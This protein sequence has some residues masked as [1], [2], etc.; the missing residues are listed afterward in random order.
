MA[1]TKIAFFETEKWEEDYLREKLAT[2]K[3]ISLDFSPTILEPNNLAKARNAGILAVFIYSKIQKEILDALP[4]LKSIATMSTGF[5]H[6][7][8]KECQ[9][10]KIKVSNVPTY[11]SNTVAEHTF[12]LILALSRKLVPSIERTRQGDFT[13][14]GL[15]GFDLSGKTIGIIGLGN[16]GKHVARIA[17]G[18]E[19]NILAFD[20]MPD[21]SFG[22]KMK[23]KFMEVDELLA[24]S[25]IITLH[26]PDN[27]KTHH[28]INKNNIEK[29]KKGACLVNTA[30]GGLVETEALLSA[31]KQDILAGAGLDVLEEECVVKEEKELLAAPFQ[32]KCDL[33]TVL[34]NH[35]L[36]QNPKVIVTPHNAFNSK[37]ALARI[38]D[39]TI[40]NILAFLKNKPINLVK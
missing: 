28:L 33:K 21:K 17:S 32:N 24:N 9:S 7:D 18:F 1:E 35:I 23:I 10:R 2:V 38:L 8:I 22:R 13:L 19:M 27:E 39:T 40:E 36:I 6:I 25:D 34:Q 15:R 3:N 14:E 31:L 20:P 11:G 12:A 29:I 4:G 16:I 37:E 5:D 26:A 30:R